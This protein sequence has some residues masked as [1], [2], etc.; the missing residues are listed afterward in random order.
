MTNPSM[1]AS[2]GDFDWA[3]PTGAYAQPA[4]ATVA[5]D[6][7]ETPPAKHGWWSG[8]KARIAALIAAG[9]IVGGGA[10]LAVDHSSGSSTTASG[11]GTGG[12]PGG[13]SGSGF[14]PGSGSGTSGGA[15]VSPTSYRLSGTITAISG[16][17]VTIRAGSGSKT[18]TVT[19]ST[20]L[21]RNGSTVVLSSFKTGDSV[22]GSTTTSGGSTLNDLMVGTPGMGGTGGTA[23]SGNGGAPGSSTSSSTGSST[24]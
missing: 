15:G 1:P 3:A 5:P 21:Q 9:A 19:S 23:P 7:T 16:S 13:S 4:A 24:T 22:F 10:A 2:G 8:T 6:A 11:Q 17:R 14:A 12:A 18:Y 20:H